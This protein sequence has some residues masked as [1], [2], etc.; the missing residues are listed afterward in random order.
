MTRTITTVSILIA[1]F[2]AL[3]ASFNHVNAATTSA[4]IFVADYDKDTGV[5][6][7]AYYDSDDHYT[8]VKFWLQSTNII[9]SSANILTDSY[10]FM[11]TN[12]FSIDKAVFTTNHHRYNWSYMDNTDIYTLSGVTD[13]NGFMDG[14][15][16]GNELTHAYMQ[17]T[18]IIHNG[19]IAILKY[20]DPNATI[21]AH[22]WMLQN[23][24]LFQY[25]A[26]STDEENPNQTKPHTVY[27]PIVANS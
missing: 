11:I 8:A 21:D 2:I 25:A 3:F 27:V 10:G 19:Q 6:Y 18:G 12:T 16:D 15:I 14:F 1:M 26:G 17:T 13:H 4:K 7:G 24:N 20:A 5:F 9:S 23:G 22:G